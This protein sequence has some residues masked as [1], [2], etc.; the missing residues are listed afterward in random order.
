VH[1]QVRLGSQKLYDIG[2]ET[3]PTPDSTAGSDSQTGTPA[4]DAGDLPDPSTAGEPFGF[5]RVPSGA[6]LNKPRDSGMPDELGLNGQVISD[7]QQQFVRDVLA[8]QRPDLQE[9]PLGVCWSLLLPREP[10]SSTGACFFHER[11]PPA[12]RN[13]GSLLPTLARRRRSRLSKT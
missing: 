1:A 9:S 7:D 2:G 6:G 12:S 11:I 10:A 3:V 8:K 5:T 4:S 13:F